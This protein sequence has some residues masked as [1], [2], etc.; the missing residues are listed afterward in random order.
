MKDEQ[1]IRTD[2]SVPGEDQI[3]GR[4]SD[5]IEGVALEEISGGVG[6]HPPPGA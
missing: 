2:E 3:D 5:E 1:L 6:G 4:E